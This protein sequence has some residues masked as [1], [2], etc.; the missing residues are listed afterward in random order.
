M[1]KK[2]LDDLV[3]ATSEVAALHEHFDTLGVRYLVAQDALSVY[4]NH[5]N[6]VRDL[7]IEQLRGIFDGSLSRWSMVGG[8]SRDVVVIIRPPSSGSH[9]FFRDHVL[10]GAPYS[11]RAVAVPTTR[12]V[13]MAVE[14]DSAAIGYGGVAYRL[15]G[16]RQISVDGFA[17]T[18]ENVG[19]DR[20][21]LAR[22]LVFYTA[23]PA[24]GVARRFIDWCLSTD[25]QRVV[26]EVGYIPLW[27]N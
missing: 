20:Y 18:P 19:L 10:S 22:Y 5:D 4:V 15:E 23:S 1:V 2:R 7:S 8:S 13:L 25:G 12:G 11:S 21:A 24:T 6:P 3:A 16:V 9:R 14:D 17:P 26:E 27:E